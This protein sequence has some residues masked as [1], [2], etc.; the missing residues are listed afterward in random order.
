MV[1]LQRLTLEEDNGEDCKDSNGN[2]LLDDFELH[3]CKSTAITNE[4]HTISG[5]LASI[6]K[7][8]QK[9]TDEYDDVKWRVVRNEFHLLKL[10]VTI[11]SECHEDIRYDEQ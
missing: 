8:R 2:N 9:P 3:Q 4:T 5:Y 7:E 11:P 1:P 6:L 10:Q